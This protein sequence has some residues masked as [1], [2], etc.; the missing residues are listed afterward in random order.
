MFPDD[1]LVA[2]AAAAFCASGVVVLVSQPRNDRAPLIESL[3]AVADPPNVI[4]LPAT[5]PDVAW[6]IQTDTRMLPLANECN[7][8]NVTPVAVGRL[9]VCAAPP[10]NEPCHAM[11]VEP[12]AASAAV[13]MFGATVLP[14]PLP[15]NASTVAAT[16]SPYAGGTSSVEPAINCARSCET[17]SA[18]PVRVFGPAFSIGPGEPCEKS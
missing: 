15:R 1:Q 14:F 10:V 11:I 3:L 13:V 2:V 5:N 6:P 12:T 17:F 4:V 8:A 7:S 16:P 18:T 9:C